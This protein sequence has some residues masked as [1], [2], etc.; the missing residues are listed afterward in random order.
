[1][2]AVLENDCVCTVAGVF[3]SGQHAQGHGA[4]EGER[5]CFSAGR[6][7]GP[8]AGGKSFMVWVVLLRACRK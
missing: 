1:M 2:T 7:E 4:G 3:L 8:G 6:R 5:V